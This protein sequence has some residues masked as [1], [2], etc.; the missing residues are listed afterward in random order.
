[1]P[2]DWQMMFKRMYSHKDPSRPIDNV[3][4][5][6]PEEKL[7]WAMEQV[8]RSVEKKEAKNADAE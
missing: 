2:E 8:R 1:L 7:D 5:D 3:V 6:L 4:D